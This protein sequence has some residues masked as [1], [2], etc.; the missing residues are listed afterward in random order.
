ML[1]FIPDSLSLVGHN[2]SFANHSEL[3][4]EEFLFWNNRSMFPW[5]KN[6]TRHPAWYNKS[7]SYQETVISSGNH[8][9]G[10]HERNE[11]HRWPLVSNPSFG[12]MFGGQL[13][14]VSGP[15]FHPTQHIVCR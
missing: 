15:C 8:S 9:G 2:S 1:V 11:S 4:P 13:V 6:H 12:P 3:I 14:N 10:L 5:D 7:P